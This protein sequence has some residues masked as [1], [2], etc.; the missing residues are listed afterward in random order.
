MKQTIRANKRHKEKVEAESVELYQK[1][2]DATPKEAADWVDANVTDF[3]S[4]KKA[5]KILAAAVS[6]HATELDKS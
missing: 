5:L 1:L 6:Y 3:A 4:A 2:V